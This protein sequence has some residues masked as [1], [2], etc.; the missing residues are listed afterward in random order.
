MFSQRTPSSTRLKSPNLELISSQLVGRTAEEW[1]T[2]KFPLCLSLSSLNLWTSN[3]A[4]P[5]SNWL[6]YCPRTVPVSLIF[7]VLKNFKKFIL[8]F[9]FLDKKLDLYKGAFLKPELIHA[10]ASTLKHFSGFGKWFNGIDFDQL[11]LDYCMVYIHHAFVSDDPD[12]FDALANLENVRAK[13]I[14]WTFCSSDE[15]EL[16]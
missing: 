15:Y 4:I 11:D 12:N 1:A 7:F 8:F 16:G 13:R 10:H 6:K 14:E 5:V 9:L 3:F 2:K